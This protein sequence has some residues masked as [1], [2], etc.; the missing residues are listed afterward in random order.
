M[1]KIDPGRR[2]NVLHIKSSFT[3]GGCLGLRSLKCHSWPCLGSFQDGRP[4]RLPGIDSS[5]HSTELHPDPI[6]NWAEW[7]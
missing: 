2:V 7:L 1:N 6:N 3:G 5:S 4:R